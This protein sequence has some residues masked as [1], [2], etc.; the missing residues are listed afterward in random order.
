LAER[1]LAAV[2]TYYPIL[3]LPVEITQDSGDF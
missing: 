2:V 1:Q 3:T